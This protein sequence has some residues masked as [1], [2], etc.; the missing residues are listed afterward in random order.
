MVTEVKSISRDITRPV[1]RELWA[2]A[3]G[4]CQFDGC[5]K[6]LYQSSV[7][8]ESVHTAQKAHIYSFSKDGP[9][10]WGP[11]KIGLTQLNDVSNLMLICH[12]CHQKI[13]SYP[14]RYSAEILI[15]WKAQHEE[16]VETVTSIASNKKSHVVMYGANIGKESS[17]LVLHDCV[18]SMFPDWYP[19]S[20]KPIL[21]SM[22]SALRDNTPEYW[23]AESLHL[24]KQFD[25]T[26]A[27]IAQDD[28]CKHFSVFALAPQP[29]LIKLGTLFTDKLD[30]ETYQLH[31]EPKGWRWNSAQ[32]EFNF[33]INEP[34]NKGGIPVLL[35]SLSDRVDN[36]RIK[37]VL[38][39][40]VSIWEITHDSPHN[41][42]LQSKFQ[43]MLFR[44]QIRKLMVE[45]KH[46]HGNTAPLHV[47][48]VMPIS[49]CIEMGR[50]RMPKADMD[51]VIYDHIPSEQLFIKSLV[52]SG[53]H[54]A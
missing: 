42:F 5:N 34:E 51:W 27:R 4:R 25:R 52:I 41:D 32:T 3:A 12:E 48:P 11:F 7:T 39:E 35:L 43:L 33:L 36:Q 19:A 16:R 24:E 53:G 45:I 10:G 23:Q 13:D 14:D 44:Q 37:A 6:I 15:A 9:R 40:Q 26:I 20:V 21:L 30:V 29:L 31:R 49:C 46:H 1:E 47:F 17:P 28:N 8:N 2:R 54:H 50:A 38:G 22:H 18:T